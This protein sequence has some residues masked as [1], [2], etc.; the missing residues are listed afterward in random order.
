MKLLE[1]KK[2][3]E[4]WWG[5]LN[6]GSFSLKACQF[7]NSSFTFNLDIFIENYLNLRGQLSYGKS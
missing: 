6:N 2:N 1:G 7:L 4:K 5:W 3:L